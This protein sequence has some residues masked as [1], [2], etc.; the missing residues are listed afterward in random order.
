MT[1]TLQGEM[2]PFKH[3]GF[4]T[5]AAVERLYPY[6][7][8][9]GMLWLGRADS[10]T[11]RPIGVKDNRH[12]VTVA[13]SRAG[14]GTTAII[15]NLCRYPGSLICLDPKGENATRTA[16]RRGGGIGNI[17]GMGQKVVVLDPFCKA[18]GP[19]TQ[20]RGTFN[21]LDSIEIISP[22]AIDQAADLANAL[23]V[24]AN[25]KDAHWDES[26]RNFI[27]ALI[28]HVKSFDLRLLF[29]ETSK[30][31]SSEPSLTIVRSLLMAGSATYASLSSSGKD[32]PLSALDGLLQSMLDNIFC[33]GAIAAAASALLSL[34]ST[35]RASIL[36]T[37]RRNTEF[38]DSPGIRS[39]VDGRSSFHPRELKEAN[40]GV[41][42]YV[43]LPSARLHTHFRWMRLIL[44]SILSASEQPMPGK[45]D[46][47]ETATGHSTLFILDE[48]AQL[49]R[50]DIIEKA[51]GLMAGYGVKLW[52]IL[53]DLTQLQR[54]YE[55]SWETFFGN[56]GIAQFFGNTDLT[57]LQY[58]S[59]KIGRY[60]VLKKTGGQSNDSDLISVSELEKILCREEE[61]QYNY[62]IPYGLQIV[63]LSGRR[64]VLAKKTRYYLDEEFKNLY[65]SND[66]LKSFS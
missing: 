31:A 28:L 9:S 34:G 2:N 61:M 36:S 54:L 56:A 42:V 19:A 5:E 12:I 1:R 15:P 66:I 62:Q 50:M 26:A 30:Y 6:L 24:I 58:L 55:S 46:L 29:G 18:E 47:G 16:A 10:Q 23:I 27:K 52:L 53:Q 35:E 39:N 59:D 13:G 48:F 38:L 17:P 41:S 11:A 32:Q 21:P 22:E 65:C 14:K 64:P 20:Y 43:C 51:A 57:T 40:G 45:I 3:Y 44:V 7:E 4:E 63:L 60:D 33:D 25:E 37:A 8:G 49:N